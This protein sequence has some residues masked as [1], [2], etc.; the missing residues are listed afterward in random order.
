MSGSEEK[1]YNDSEFLTEHLGFMPERVMD[2]IYDSTN[3]VVY[4]AMKGMRAYFESLPSVDH[5]S[6]EKVGEVFSWGV[7]D[8][9]VEAEIDNAFNQLQKYFIGNVLHLPPNL[10]IELDHYKGLDL[11]CTEEEK[12]MLDQQLM[13]A[14]ADVSAQITFQR[15]LESE[16][17]H[18]DQQL[19]SLERYHHD[20]SF[21]STIPRQENVGPIHETMRVVTDQVKQL[22][23]SVSRVLETISRDTNRKVPL[24][25]IDMRTK[26]LQETVKSKLGELQVT[27][28]DPHNGLPHSQS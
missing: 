25:A 11:D 13:E 26:Y 5:Q 21:L 17:Y 19:K 8:Q 18:L 23:Q 28:T 27:M 14:R 3:R 9:H 1:E 20:L 10:K 6:L 7:Y 15:R 16:E 12:E 24:V 4:E 2:E 22:N